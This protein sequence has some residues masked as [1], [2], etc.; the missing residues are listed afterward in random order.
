MPDP[1][2]GRPALAIKVT[3]FGDDV[4]RGPRAFQLNAAAG[5]SWEIFSASCFH[6]AGCSC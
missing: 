4:R 5:K 1:E 2:T 3:L 6:H